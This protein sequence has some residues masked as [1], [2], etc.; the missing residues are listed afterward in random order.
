MQKLVRHFGGFVLGFVLIF[1]L[2]LA[3]FV[4]SFSCYSFALGLALGF[5]LGFTLGF[6][7][8]LCLPPFDG[9]C[10]LCEVRLAPNAESVDDNTESLQHDQVFRS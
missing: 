9:P 10:D 3:F 2:D 8:P 7:V 6:A 1:A 4:R 5:A